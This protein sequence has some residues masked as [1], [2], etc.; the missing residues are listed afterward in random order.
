MRLRK[1]F[2]SKH[3]NSVRP[4]N[5]ED[6]GDPTERFIY[7][8][9][10]TVCLSL[11]YS[12]SASESE[13]IKEA[14]E[15]GTEGKALQEDGSSR[16]YLRC[17][18]AV[19][20]SLL[21]RLIGGKYDLGP[22]H[23]LSVFYGNK[24]FRDDYS[25]V[26][27]AYILDWRRKGPM[28]LKYRIYQRIV[29]DIP[30]VVN[31]NTTSSELSVKDEPVTSQTTDIAE[32][33]QLQASKK[34]QDDATQ[35]KSEDISTV[36][37]A[38]P[39]KEV[40]LEISESGVM[41]VLNVGATET[42]QLSETV[43]SSSRSNDETTPANPPPPPPP[44][45]TTS[46]DAPD[47]PTSTESAKSSEKT[48]KP[49]PQSLPTVN[50]PTLPHL[51]APPSPTPGPVAAP[52]SPSK[53]T[54]TSPAGYKTL[55]TPPKTWNPSV[56]RPA[57]KRSAGAM[58]TGSSVKMTTTGEASG[59]SANVNADLT[60]PSTPKKSK[61]TTSLQPPMASASPPKAPK[62]FKVRNS[63]QPVASVA[64]STN[65]TVV[66]SSS[67]SSSISCSSTSSTSSSSTSSSSTSISSTSR[68]S[69]SSTSTSSKNNSNNSNN[70]SSSNN[71]SNSTYTMTTATATMPSTA[72]SSL[73]SVTES[74]VQEVAVNL[75]KTSQSGSTK[76]S[77][78]KDA[79]TAAAVAAAAAAASTGC[80]EAAAKLRVLL[81]PLMA[82]ISSSQQLPPPPTSG[83]SGLVSSSASMAS[84]SDSLQLR[85]PSWMNLGG[86]GRTGGPRSPLSLPPTAAAT[87]LNRSPLPAHLLS[88]FIASHAS[89]YHPYLA[90][91]MSLGLSSLV[92]SGA[93]CMTTGDVKH[94]SS[95]LSS[96]PCPVSSA[97]STGPTS[98]S[99]SLRSPPAGGGG[100]ATPTFS[101]NNLPPYAAALSPLLPSL[102]RELAG[103]LYTNYSPH[104]SPVRP[105]SVGSATT[106]PPPL[107]PPSVSAGFHQSLPP[108]VTSS[109][110]A[111]SAGSKSSPSGLRPLMPRRSGAPPPP[112]GP[113]R[114]SPPAPKNPP[115]LVSIKGV[116]QQEASKNC[117]VVESSLKRLPASNKKSGGKDDPP[118]NNGTTTESADP[119][120]NPAEENGTAQDNPASNVNGRHCESPATTKLPD[121]SKKI[122]PASVDAA[123]VDSSKSQAMTSST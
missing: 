35:V 24:C 42:T 122:G 68:S 57:T 36:S 99:S 89:H 15:G 28:R 82:A 11:E 53:K 46:N 21:K 107:P 22:N 14:S 62:F 102:Q 121:A 64:T 33:S 94:T 93:A 90:P 44:P 47:L 101:L 54:S 87:F 75:T 69:T 80:D 88:S 58:Q 49:P 56:S 97:S 10:E 25:L 79:A 105:T 6:Y 106:P 120:P 41:S 78:A 1:D 119:K 118:A 32:S 73:N 4:Q 52:P 123:D 55:K 19:T 37:P 61:K 45:S 109:K 110:G 67:I 117:V 20:V 86:G 60:K 76:K 83:S 13:D 115:M 70:N 5:P 104:Y 91:Q 40:Q 98:K 29:S 7:S 100:F 17:P 8:P 92:S 27:V 96:P 74:P 30:V 31:G 18:A 39:E 114:S 23:T 108:T 81:N 26:D 34:D 112:L 2:Y 16:R 9:D 51:P 12:S 113:I 103:S 48:S 66:T 84:L 59:D 111:S 72:I 43:L 85:F 50:G 77:T 95:P 65:G 63:T 71:S 38:E 116:E 3:P